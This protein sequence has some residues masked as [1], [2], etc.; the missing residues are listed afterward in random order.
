MSVGGHAANVPS[1]KR[2]KASAIPIFNIIDEPST[3]DVRKPEHRTIDS[4]SAGKIVFKDV[5]FKY[6]TRIE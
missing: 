3:L 4:V 1:I 5:T 2:A 6:P